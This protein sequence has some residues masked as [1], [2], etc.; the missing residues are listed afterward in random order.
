MIYYNQKEQERYLKMKELKL[1]TLNETHLSPSAY[2]L[3][4]IIDNNALELDKKL[5]VDD[6]IRVNLVKGLNQAYQENSKLFRGYKKFLNK[7][8]K[9][10]DKY[11]NIEANFTDD[12]MS[13]INKLYHCFIKIDGAIDE[14]MSNEDIADT[15]LSKNL[16][17]NVKYT[18]DRN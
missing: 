17:K 10:Y 14:L 7:V 16:I 2:S 13:D 12:Y 11:K 3:Y 1:L 8:N 9:F 18:S 6:E 5:K 15:V 4:K